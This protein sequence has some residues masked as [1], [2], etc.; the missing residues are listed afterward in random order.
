MSRTPS[1][2]AKAAQRLAQHYAG[3]FS[4]PPSP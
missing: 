1:V 4:T 2:A 3:V